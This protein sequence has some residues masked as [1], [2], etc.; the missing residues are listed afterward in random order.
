[1]ES[2]NLSKLAQEIRQTESVQLIGR[3]FKKKEEKA[4]LIAAV[5]GKEDCVQMILLC[6]ALSE[7]EYPVR[8]FKNNR[9]RLLNIQEQS[10][11]LLDWVENVRICNRSIAVAQKERSRIDWEE[12]LLLAELIYQGW[13]PRLRS[14]LECLQMVTL[15]L[16][17]R[18]EEIHPLLLRLQKDKKLPVELLKNS[19][20]SA[21]KVKKQM[22]L[23]LGEENDRHFTLTIRGKEYDFWI[24][25][26]Y[27]YDPWEEIEKGDPNFTK[28]EW[29]EFMK[30]WEKICPKGKRLTVIE[31]ENEQQIQLNFYDEEYLN[32][33][34]SRNMNIGIWMSRQ[35]GK[36]GFPLRSEILQTPYPAQEL[37]KCR[38][39]I[40]RA[41][42][43]PELETLTFC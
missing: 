18:W 20:P 28:E 41:Y 26:V 2:L 42:L 14:D 33:E 32:K 30:N 25:R 40:L 39:E 8:A 13:E 1:M 31:Y 17:I 37:K 3:Y 21:E 34:S 29:D 9:E 23:T 24:E 11:H 10:V 12:M 19:F 4:E 16:D 7:K 35:T 38:V 6:N 15:T 5:K 27:Q 43:P 36:H 22:T